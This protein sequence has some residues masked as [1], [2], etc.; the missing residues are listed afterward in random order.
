LVEAFGKTAVKVEVEVGVE[1]AV[2]ASVEQV[3]GII[4]RNG[5]IKTLFE[6]F[7]LFVKYFEESFV[8][9]ACIA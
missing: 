7:N 4:I 8:V 5:R 3:I 9:R 2:Q 1:A 6:V